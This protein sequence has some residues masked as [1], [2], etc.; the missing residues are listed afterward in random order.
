VSASESPLPTSRI[1]SRSGSRRER[2]AQ[3]QV[4]ALRAV[5]RI[6]P[7]CKLW[8]FL[9]LLGS[10]QQ[11]APCAVPALIAAAHPLCLHLHNVRRRPVR[12]ERT[13]RLSRLV[14][15]HALILYTA[16]NA[17]RLAPGMV[18]V[19]LAD[20]GILATSFMH[21]HKHA[22]IAAL[23]C[24][25]PHPWNCR[26]SALEVILPLHY[27]S[28][29]HVPFQR[30]PLNAAHVDMMT[31]NDLLVLHT[32]APD[33]RRHPAL[34]PTRYTI[35]MEHCGVSPDFRQAHPAK[36][37]RSPGPCPTWSSSLC[38]TALSTLAS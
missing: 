26:P 37:R 14:S 5:E 18:P 3:L 8:R 6:A 9:W 24:R 4:L 34:A 16:R 29:P 36:R 32:V 11:L 13:V 28:T 1:L 20:A 31:V 17:T 30:R 10:R 27:H 23:R 22:P 33:G 2:A 7:S 38:Q 12:H 35:V 21:T 25:V 15:F 19:L